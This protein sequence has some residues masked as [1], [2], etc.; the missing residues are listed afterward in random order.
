[1]RGFARVAL[2]LSIVVAA[3]G[4][5][6]LASPAHHRAQALTGAPRAAESASGLAFDRADA[7]RLRHAASRSRTQF[8]WAQD[9]R[10]RAVL[11]R[12]AQDLALAAQAKARAQ[13]A[14]LQARN[15]AQSAQAAARRA[16]AQQ[17]LAREARAAQIRQAVQARRAA[18]ASTPQAAATPPPA[19]IAPAG[20]ENYANS[21]SWAASVHATRVRQCESSDNYAADTGNG[22]YGAYQF[23][24]GTWQ[25]VGGLGYPEQNSA[26]EQDYRAYLLWQRSGWSSWG[27]A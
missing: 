9:V 16:A 6:S 10:L 24:E 19:P 7:L 12:R 20:A 27:C 11:A 4:V 14:A 13:A 23:S 1:M 3:V 15:A 18:T 5:V 21:S 25:S 17:Q 26:R 22:Y 8:L 2:Y